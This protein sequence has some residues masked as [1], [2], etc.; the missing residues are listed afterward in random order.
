[1]VSLVSVF[2]LQGALLCIVALPLLATAHGAAPLGLFDAVGGALV[3]FGVVYE[4]TADLQLA[5]FRADAKNVGAVMDRGLWRTSR[6]PNYFAEAVVWWGLYGLAL[7]AGAPWAIVGPLLM[8]TL[9]L[10][11]S[12]VSLLERTIVERRPAYAAYIEAT[13]AFVPWPRRAPHASSSN[14]PSSRT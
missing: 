14:T 10:K 8:T 9:L 2:W 6:H 3:I 12:G 13:S 11:V 7:G 4:G 5:R 1:L